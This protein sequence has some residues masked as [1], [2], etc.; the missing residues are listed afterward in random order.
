MGGLP[1]A[2]AV[3]AAET[4]AATVAVAHAAPLHAVHAPALVH[5]APAVHTTVHTAPVVQHVGYQVH[6]QVQHV[7]QV[8]VQKHT[9]QHVTQHVINHAPVVG[10]YAGLPLAGLPVAGLPVVAAAAPAEESE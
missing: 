10:A 3:V 9:T 1:A 2:H 8:S 4:P 6:H 7:P 5:A